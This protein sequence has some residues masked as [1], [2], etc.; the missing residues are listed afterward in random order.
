MDDGPLDMSGRFPNLSVT[1]RSLVRMDRKSALG[2]V[3]LSAILFGG[4]G[5]W[6]KALFRTDLT[7]VQVTGF[8]IIVAGLCVAIFASLRGAR[9]FND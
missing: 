5:V 1:Q 4:S 6:G 7:P 8:R 2:F 3:L 9:E